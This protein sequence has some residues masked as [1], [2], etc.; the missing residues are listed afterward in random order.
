MRSGF[1][2]KLLRWHREKNAR[3]MPWKGE[4][5]PYKIWLSEIILQQTRVEQGKAYYERFLREFPTLPHLARARDQKVFKL[6]EGL[7]YYSRCR[8]L[9][10]TARLIEKEVIDSDEL[11]A[12]I[13]ENS[14]SPLIVPVADGCARCKSSAEAGSNHRRPCRPLARPSSPAHTRAR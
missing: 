11:K 14:P 9:L 8:N 10:T 3:E 6:W 2:T 7:G 13:E 5:D 1:T 12:I 4:K